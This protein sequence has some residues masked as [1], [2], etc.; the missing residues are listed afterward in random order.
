MTEANNRPDTN[1]AADDALDGDLRKLYARHAAGERDVEDVMQQIGERP[2]PAARRPWPAIAAAGIPA[3]AIAAMLAWLMLGGTPPDD[4]E[5]VAQPSPPSNVEA[6]DGGNATQFPPPA[7]SDSVSIPQRTTPH[8]DDPAASSGTDG[9]ASGSSAGAVPPRRTVVLRIPE[10]EGSSEARQIEQVKWEVD[11]I[12]LGTLDRAAPGSP[13]KLLPL[14]VDDVVKGP[15]VAGRLV[16][17]D[18]LPVFTCET[19]A[20]HFRP[21]STGFRPGDQVVAYLNRN[22]DSWELQ[23]LQPAT[24]RFRRLLEAAR[25]DDPRAELAPLLSVEAGGLDDDAQMMLE[26]VL[27]PEQSTP[28]L[29][30]VLQRIPGELRGADD[31][32]KKLIVEKQLVPLCWMLALRYEPRL[33]GP[34]VEALALLEGKA[35][36]DARFEVSYPLGIVLRVLVV[37]GRAKELAEDD[38]LALRRLWHDTLRGYTDEARLPPAAEFG[39]RR[40]RADAEAAIEHIYAIANGDTVTLLLEEQDRRPLTRFHPRVVGALVGTFALDPHP[41]EHTPWI[42]ADD[43]RRMK[44]AWLK[45]LLEFKPAAEPSP[46]EAAFIG[47]VVAGLYGLSRR[48]LP[49]T[50]EEL[51]QVRMRQSNVPAWFSDALA[52]LART[53]DEGR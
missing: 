8:Q 51:A 9:A 53:A 19:P 36:E 13:E 47:A 12:F 34:A 22:G 10:A 1:Q 49:L 11:L 40:N 44:A 21:A 43:L 30:S 41:L 26:V 15:E 2:A 38:V 45:T 52:R 50:D 28:L 23:R 31:E 25:R 35:W 42:G 27:T 48:D 33:L 16:T 37:T 4:V 18:E 3:A 46:D 17:R 20:P 7:I 6:A 5:R 32:R 39:A 29:L 14:R 24:L